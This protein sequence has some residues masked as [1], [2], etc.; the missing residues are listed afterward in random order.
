MRAKTKRQCTQ[1][2]RTGIYEHSSITLTVI[3]LLFVQFNQAVD[4]VCAA[5]ILVVW[6]VVVREVEREAVVVRGRLVVPRLVV[7]VAARVVVVTISGPVYS[8]G[9]R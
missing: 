8:K 3:E 2:V 9:P 4:V 7:V 1:F 5:V 6:A